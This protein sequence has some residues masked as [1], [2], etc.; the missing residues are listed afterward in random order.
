MRFS[1]RHL[2]LTVLLTLPVWTQAA[3]LLRCYL[4]YAGQTQ[5]ISSRLQ[6][7]PYLI[8]SEDIQG[9][10]RFKAVMIGN[11]D[12]PDYIKLYAYFQGS[13]GDVLVHQ[14]SYSGPFKFTETETTFTPLNKIYAGPLERELDYHCSLQ[15]V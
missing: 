14:A 15:K 11:H 8:Q 10:F 7:D 3:P 4:S 9:R 6:T 12:K 1:L 13:G 2:L 5:L